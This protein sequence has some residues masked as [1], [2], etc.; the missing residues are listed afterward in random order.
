[1][2]RE[3]RDNEVVDGLPSK[4]LAHTAAE[5]QQVWNYV[6][7]VSRVVRQISGGHRDA[8]AQAAYFVAGKLYD[9]D[10][11]LFANG[12]Q[13]LLKRQRDSW[14]D[15]ILFHPGPTSVPGFY[16]PVAVELLVSF[17]PLREI[18][19]K[20]SRSSSM[21]PAFLAKADIG[22]L[23]IGARTLWNVEQ[24]DAVVEMADILH[25]RGLLWLEELSDPLMLEDRVI[26]GTL[27]YVDDAV[28]LELVLAL[29]GKLAARRVV[30]AWQ[31]DP[32]RGPGLMRGIEKLSRQFGPVYRSDDTGLNIAVLCICYDLWSRPRQIVRG[33]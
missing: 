23:G 3:P 12:G 16:C 20:V 15:E 25:K 29:G 7:K 18:R 10:F 13:P 11:H 6:P 21:V 31:E 24:H 4:I 9:E 33:S 19:S 26:D 30:S 2:W 28:G 32:F 8:L 17:E 27:R 5:W 1:M 14:F 22:E